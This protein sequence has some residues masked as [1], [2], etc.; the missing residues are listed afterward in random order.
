M[1]TLLSTL[2]LVSAAF[3]QGLPP[4][5]MPPENPTTPAKVVLGK[6]LFYEEQM[7]SDNSSACASCHM[8][9]VAGSDPRTSTPG[10][11]HPGP[12]GLF[13]TPDDVR[14]SRGIV[15]CSGSGTLTDD[16]VFFPKA[17]VTGRKAPAFIGNQ[18]DPVQFWDGRAGGKVHDPI[19]NQVV[20]WSGGSLESQALLP[21]LAG[22]MSCAGRNWTVIL[23]KLTSARPMRLASAI[24][25]DI[26]AALSANP[27]YP[28]LFNAAFGSPTLTASHVAFAL[29]AYERT[30]VPD[31]AP[32]DNYLGG[33]L[34]A[35]T[36]NQIA[37][38]NVF[39]G[40][41]GCA[42]CHPSPIFANSSFHNIGV[43]PPA[44][45]MGR[46]NATNDNNDRG[47][48]KTPS[49]RNASLRGP[50]FHNGKF[51][52]LAD[53]IDFYD[54]G[55]DFTDNLD[56]FITPLNLTATQKSQLLDFLTNALLDPR[57]PARLAP[58]DRPTLKS[59]GP[60]DPLPYGTGSI[61]TG[62]FVPQ[63]VAPAPAMIGSDHFGF[64]VSGGIGSMPAY[65]MIS[66]GA[67]P[68]GNFYAG[69]PLWIVPNASL[70]ILP[71]TLD[72]GPVGVPGRGYTSLFVT[73]PEM[74]AL[75]GVSV[76]AQWVLGDPN[77][78]GGMAVSN[79]L[80]I[81]FSRP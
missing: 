58:F 38:L 15:K 77:V 66:D 13:G 5:P 65:L 23:A 29:A 30:L 27:T 3:S 52:T 6:M 67:L 68:P 32:I 49:L 18:W 80:A 35:L 24:T 11:L 2:V 54:R 61:G 81:T 28:A 1:R 16:G 71:M 63:M 75:N 51:A 70:N 12:D 72:G 46:T 36:P 20:I 26:A 40:V 10:N 39:T 56:P 33:N 22:E 59:E 45:D 76:Y 9:E 55:G 21:P 69:L 79:G 4:V 37:G 60:A 17:I 41:A 53:V 74:P 7:S 64:G 34:T 57:V 50:Y 43:R 42:F 14:G 25:P 47:K 19:T 31:Q 78:V 44:E 48:F 62:G 8:P 73:I